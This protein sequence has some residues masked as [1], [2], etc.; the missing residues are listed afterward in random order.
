MAGR[1]LQRQS[2][3][4]GRQGLT[5]WPNLPLGNL[6]SLI[7]HP[8]SQYDTMQT[9]IPVAGKTYVSQLDPSLSLYVESIVVI[10]A[11][12]DI[13]A[14]FVVTCCPPEGKDDPSVP[15]YEFLDDEWVSF[16]F[17]PAQEGM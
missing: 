7:P 16:R 14:G 8:I 11:D 4:R 15:G 10:E 1:P 12:A 6:V 2:T 5:G 9:N 13:E 3:G 17:T